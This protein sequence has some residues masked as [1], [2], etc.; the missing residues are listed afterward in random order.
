MNLLKEV[1]DAGQRIRPVVAVGRE[2][3]HEDRL[4]GDE[5]VGRVDLNHG[6]ARVAPAALSD[7]MH[8]LAEVLAVDRALGTRVVDDLKLPLVIALQRDVYVDGAG[9][10]EGAGRLWQMQ[11]PYMLQERLAFEI[12]FDTFEGM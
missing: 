10:L 8:H 4:V 2:L 11:P 5:A 3:A 1:R 9:H 7:E 6:I 12:S